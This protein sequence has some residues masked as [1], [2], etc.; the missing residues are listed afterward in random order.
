M[1]FPFDKNEPHFWSPKLKIKSLLIK[2]KCPRSVNKQN[3]FIPDKKV[4]YA[5]ILESIITLF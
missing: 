2:K 3:L 1:L 5:F 4:I